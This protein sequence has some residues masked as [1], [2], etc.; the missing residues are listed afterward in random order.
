MADTTTTDPPTGETTTEQPPAP[1]PGPVKTYRGNCHC[2]AFVF[3][4]DA[5]E[6]VT[7]SDCNC[8]ICTKRAYLWLVPEKPI[9]V[10]KDEGKLVG[11]RFASK[12]MDHQ[13]GL[14]TP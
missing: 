9:V 8:S 5:P 14:F 13:V 3:E 7:G 11:Y 12:N 1:P 4:V 6:I 10:V 2:G